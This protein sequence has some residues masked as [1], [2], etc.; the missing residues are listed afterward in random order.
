[1]ALVRK[2][3]ELSDQQNANMFNFASANDHFKCRPM[4]YDLICS[5]GPRYI[6]LMIDVSCNI[7]RRGA[8]SVVVQKRNFE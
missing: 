5:M 1:M 6:Q 3:N 7:K 4:N 8:D 2:K